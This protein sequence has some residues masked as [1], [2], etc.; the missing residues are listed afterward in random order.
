MYSNS[1]ARIDGDVRRSSTGVALATSPP[2]PAVLWKNTTLD[3]FRFTLDDDA[4]PTFRQRILYSDVHWNFGHGPLLVFFGGE[5]ACEDF[6][7]NS[8][9]LFDMARPLGAKVVFLEHRYYGKSLPFGADSYGNRELRFLTVEQALADMSDVL[10]RRGELFGCVAG[11]CRAVLFGGS[12]GGMQAAWHR[13]KYPHLSRGAIAASAPVDIYPGEGKSEAFWRATIRTYSKFGTPACAAWI[14]NAIARINAT[15][16]G[17]YGLLSSSFKTCAPLATRNDVARLLLYVQGALST[18][19]MVDYPFAST[20]VTPM[21]ASPVNVACAAAGA[22]P[23]NASDAWLWRSLNTVQNIFLNFTA[24][25]KCH[26]VS[27]EL[28]RS[29]LLSTSDRPPQH[30]HIR[31]NAPTLG[32]ITRPWNYMACSSLILEPLTSDGDG[33]FVPREDQIESVER[34]CRKSFGSVTTRPHWMPRA[35][36]NGVQ[37]ARSLRNVY[38]SD[39][40]KDPWRVG[41]MPNA[42]NELSP[43]GSVVHRLIAGAA[44][45]QDLRF[46]DPSDSA[47][48]IAARAEELAYVTKWL[49]ETYE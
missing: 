26:N 15:T 24:Q 44:H 37:L 13:L 49:A 22:P 21:P 40:E 9:A 34:A 25:L 33:F 6:Y 32:D 2:P 48:L 41:G 42:T 17:S 45:H 31:A 27:A 38:F 4:P 35:Y 39:G 47:D 16:Q 10:A 5:G 43:D 8:G 18:E 28:L 12:Y 46:A 3:W 7:A 36:G 23:P 20:F 1:S 30:H 19:A 14:E 29:G 11:G